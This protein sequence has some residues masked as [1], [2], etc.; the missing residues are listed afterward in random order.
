M[1]DF[2]KQP[3]NKKQWADKLKEMFGS[4][5]QKSNLFPKILKEI[6]SDDYYFFVLFQMI[7]KRLIISISIWR[8]ELE[9]FETFIG[10]T[11][12]FS[13]V[14]TDICFRTGNTV[15]L[16]KSW[17]FVYLEIFGYFRIRIVYFHTLNHRINT[18]TLVPI[19]K[20]SC[21]GWR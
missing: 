11:E 18:S 13:K 10:F 19:T 4:I 8:I 16:V 3:L 1:N 15:G 17:L 12:R 9:L 7:E 2:L 5:Q 6:Y 14:T 21:L 20:W